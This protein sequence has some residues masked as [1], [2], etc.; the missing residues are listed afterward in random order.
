M[1]V[2]FSVGLTTVTKRILRRYPRHADFIDINLDLD[3][4]PQEIDR[5]IVRPVGA[6]FLNEIIDADRAASMKAAAVAAA[7]APSEAKTTDDAMDV[8]EAE[9]APEAD[10]PTP[11]IASPESPE[12]S[13]PADAASSDHMELN[14]QAL[15]QAS[16]SYIRSVMT[17][18]MQGNS[19]GL[20]SL[21]ES[22]I[23]K[24]TIMV[25]HLQSLSLSESET[26]VRDAMLQQLESLGDTVALETEM[27]LCA[28]RVSYG[29]R[30][31]QSAFDNTDFECIWRWEANSLP[32]FKDVSQ[33]LIKETRALRN[34]YSRAIRAAAT[35][36]QHLQ[37]KF[38]DEA[39]TLAL[40]EKAVKAM[41]EIEKFKEKRREIELKRQHDLEEKMKRE[42]AKE[43]KRKE[44]EEADLLKKQQQEE[45]AAAKAAAKA[46]AQAEKDRKKAEE[47]AKKAEEEA[48][49]AE[50]EAKK[51]QKL[52]KQKS[53]FTSFFKPGAA[54]GSA[55]KA[56]P[57][58]ASP[59]SSSANLS[60]A[61]EGEANATASGDKTATAA[62]ATAPSKSKGSAV[63][64]VDLAAEE[65]RHREFVATLQS[66]MT[67]ADI[68]RSYVERRAAK[69]AA[70]KAQRATTAK[71]SKTITVPVEIAKLTASTAAAAAFG[72]EQGYIEIEHR[73][74]RNRVN[75]YSYWEDTRPAYVGTW[76]KKSRLITGRRPFAQDEEMLR[77]DYD[78]EEEWE[79]EG[80]GEDI[81][82][83]DGS[84][85]E[86]DDEE[87]G[88]ELE[89]DDFFRHDN[90]FGSDIDSDDEGM[91]CTSLPMS[92]GKMKEESVGPRFI[93]NK[94]WR[95]SQATVVGAEGFL[96][97]D[98]SQAG[99]TW[100]ASPRPEVSWCTECVLDDEAQ[101]LAQ[102]TCVVFTPANLRL[103]TTTAAPTAA[104]SSAAKE[105]ATGAAPS[106][107]AR[108]RAP[109][110]G[111]AAAVTPDGKAKAPSGDATTEEAAETAGSSSAAKV[112]KGF[113]ETKV[114]LL[115]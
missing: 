10:Q 42:E 73:T 57:A 82:M 11:A 110:G 106:S 68:Q 9:A 66:N 33:K 43:K 103:V 64:V 58:A 2:S 18:C 86:E 77:Y 36:I 99:R 3:S 50:E 19:C 28:S 96:S 75:T 115:H 37:K 24:L 111:E 20:G 80:E 31:K 94:A 89:Y 25:Q 35:L 76:S 93:T 29:L 91:V 62:V 23:S 74:F 83:S 87:G 49:K 7:A 108:K 4:I 104:P 13:T 72:E 26:R 27:K 54:G 21:T 78:S 81:A 52:H 84:R 15:A 22:V 53:F 67:M 101:K 1:L 14:D 102:Y 61:A 55:T 39:K 79:E 46:A 90:D 40:E 38:D 34:R 32:S 113:D 44:K 107:S 114:S 45:A 112:I 100:M 59:S 70:R 63:T 12:A 30:D 48:R 88:N 98:R 105:T 5:F 47:E 71:R 17:R 65:E 51:Q 109:K 56:T 6:E 60:A 41:A 92:L 8:D 97:L 95:G 85:D 16:F 69:L